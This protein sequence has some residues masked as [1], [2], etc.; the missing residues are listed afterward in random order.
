MPTALADAKRRLASNFVPDAPSS[1]EPILAD[2]WVVSSLLQKSIR[3]G[4]GE[5]AQRAAHTLFKSKGSA[6]WRRLMVIAFE[7]IGVGSSDVLVMT[8]AAATD[9]SWRKR[10]GGDA[11]VVMALARI[12]AE[13]AKDRSS[14][15]VIGAGDHPSLVN[16]AQVMAKSSI[17]TKI[18]TIC[19]PQLSMPHR[20]VAARSI[21]GTADAPNRADLAALSGSF[22]LSGVPEELIVA[23]EIAAV[24][25]R[26]PITV[27]VP[28]IW[29]AA[30]TG[31]V[32]SIRDCPV[33]PSPVVGG[34]PLY[35][36]DMHT[37]LGREAIWQ[38]ALENEAMRICLGLHVPKKRWRDA[39]YNSAFYVDAA[40]VS[41]R[42]MWDQSESLEAFGIERD[43][44]VAGVRPEG[45][46]PLLQTVRENLDHLNR[47]RGEVLLR[48]S[49]SAASN[50]PQSRSLTGIEGGIG[51]LPD[52]SLNIFIPGTPPSRWFKA[53]S[54]T[55]ELVYIRVDYNVDGSPKYPVE[56]A[57]FQIEAEAEDMCAKEPTEWV[58]NGVL[59][60]RKSAD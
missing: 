21:W 18:A 36:L 38:F 48:S 26:E 40:P 4:D 1:L 30:N 46:Q 19:D 3:R 33:A 9:P 24:R 53:R 27:M 45:H 37:R 49:P 2:P 17:E 39:A 10:C 54:Q 29:L 51:L 34:V 52:G 7:D 6:I 12:M 43:L 23:T 20:A 16:V 57:K 35:A 13:A 56:L 41:R 59:W 47:L 50:R 42:L 58:R 14:D 25:T 22:R 8:A 44:S 28:L 11:H 31:Q 55:G 15:Y 60:Q 5:V 32:P